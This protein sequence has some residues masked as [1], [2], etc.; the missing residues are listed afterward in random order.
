[1]RARERSGGSSGMLGTARL[2][3]D[4]GS[5][6]GALFLPARRDGPQYALWLE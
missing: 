6:A 5:S 4:N 3:E 2:S 1:M